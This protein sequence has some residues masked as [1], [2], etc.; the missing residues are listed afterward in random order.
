MPPSMSD[1]N[2]LHNEQVY[3]STEAAAAAS[4]AEEQTSYQRTQQMLHGLSQQHE[5]FVAALERHGGRFLPGQEG[6]YTEWDR[7]AWDLE[8]TREEVKVYAYS[9]M[10]A[11]RSHRDSDTDTDNLANVGAAGNG[12]ASVSMDRVPV[13]GVLPDDWTLEERVLFDTLL[14]RYL[15][16]NAVETRENPL[17]GSYEWEEQVAAMIPTRST[18]EVRL[19]YRRFYSQRLFRSFQS[20]KK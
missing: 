10:M 14:A 5:Q 2:G 11:L 6:G 3:E 12:T 4:V 19:R 1:A 15:P 17:D 16:A 8:W 13:H 7:I 9:Y 20:N 18:M